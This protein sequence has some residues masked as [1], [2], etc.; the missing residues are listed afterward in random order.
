AWLDG[1]YLV[2]GNAGYNDGIAINDYTNPIIYLNSGP[3]GSAFDGVITDVKIDNVNLYSTWSSNITVPTAPAVSG[4]STQVLISATDSA[5]VF[6][7]SANTVVYT[8]FTIA[9]GGTE[10]GISS[11]GSIY[12][13]GTRFGNVSI[14]GTVT[15]VGGLY[16]AVALPSENVYIWYASSSDV[17]SFKMSVRA[18]HNDPSTC[19][20]LADITAALDSTGGLVYSVGNRVTSNAAATETTFGV[21]VD[22]SVVSGQQVLV[23]NAAV[24]GDTVFFTY[25]ITEFTTSHAT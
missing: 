10:L 23:V 13:P 14:S 25:S 5:N 16:P 17:S 18:Q 20:E 3:Y 9:N 22:N 15:T 2:N 19:V 7:N 24:T 8:P 11:D 6:V 12:L 1:E 21:L 4:Y